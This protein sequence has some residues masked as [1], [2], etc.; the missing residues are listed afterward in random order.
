MPLYPPPSSGSGGGGPAVLPNWVAYTPTIGA[1]A[2]ALGAV[3]SVLGAYMRSGTTVLVRVSF[4]ITDNGTGSGF[5][6]LTLPF[7]SVGA[8]HIAMGME[9]QSALIGLIGF[10]GPGSNI[11][12]I[13]DSAGNYPG[14]AGRTFAINGPFETSSAAVLLKTGEIVTPPPPSKLPWET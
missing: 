11:C 3:G 6:S 7:T 4:A 12:Y 5:L 2:G 10:I 9:V 8:Y 14:A 1:Y 13:K